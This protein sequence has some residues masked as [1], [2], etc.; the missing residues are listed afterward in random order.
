M[1]GQLR[2]R[3]S[4]PGAQHGRRFGPPNMPLPFWP[5]MPQISGHSREMKKGYCL[6]SASRLARYNPGFRQCKRTHQMH[7][8]LV[9][10]NHSCVPSHR[11]GFFAIVP[12]RIVDQNRHPGRSPA[13][14][15]PQKEPRSPVSVTFDH[16]IVGLWGPSCFT[17]FFAHFL[18]SAGNHNVGRLPAQSTSPLPNPRPVPP[19]VNQRAFAFQTEWLASIHPPLPV[20]P[21]RRCQALSGK[22]PPRI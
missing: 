18:A 22:P 6:S 13:S 10:Q 1:F 16:A 2:R 8:Q 11:T 19:P 5:V 17:G 7:I 3:A 15:S 20:P 14:A 9:L 21:V 4:S 12:P